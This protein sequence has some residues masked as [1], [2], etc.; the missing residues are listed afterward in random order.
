MVILA[1]DTS[2]AGGSAARRPRRRRRPIVVERAGDATRTHGERLPRELMA[3]LREAGVDAS[4][5][6]IVS[7]WR[8]GPGRS[9]ACASASRRCRGSRSRA[10]C[11]SR[12]SRRSKRSRG[13]AREPDRRRSPPGWTR[14][15]ARCS[16]RCSRRTAATVLAPADR[17]RRRSAT[18]DAWRDALAPFARVR[19]VGDGAV[20]YRDVDPRAAR[21]AGGDRRRGADAGRRPSAGSPRRSPDRAVAPARRS[22][23]STSAGRTSSWR[24]IAAQAAAKP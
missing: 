19:F 21:R 16:R 14:I 13:S 1:L 6:S 8:S 17:A 12:R 4:R 23:R 9:P 18:L 11:R 22:C 2:S 20:R 15:A 7:R 24:A 5:T 10:G 3:V